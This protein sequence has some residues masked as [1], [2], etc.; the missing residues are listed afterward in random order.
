LELLDAERCYNQTI[1]SYNQARADYQSAIW[2]LEQAV[3]RPLR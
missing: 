2:Q 1:N 3:G